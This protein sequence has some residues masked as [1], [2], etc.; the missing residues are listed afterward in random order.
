MFYKVHMRKGKLDQK[1]RPYYRIVE[2]TGSVNFVIWDQIGGKIKWVHTSDL[3]LVEIEEWDVPA[4]EQRKKMVWQLIL[5]EI[6]NDRTEMGSVVEN[7]ERWD[8]DIPLAELKRVNEDW[9]EIQK[10][11]I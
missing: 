8:P 4:R 6:K 1:W 9:R 7:L 5:A 2:Q 11:G 3:K 10:K